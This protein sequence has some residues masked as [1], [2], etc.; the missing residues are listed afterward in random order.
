MSFKKVVLIILILF[1]SNLYSIE[2][3][4]L[5]IGNSNYA[6]APLAN[7]KND[8]L[9]VSEGF[10][11]LGYKVT[12]IIDGNKQVMEEAVAK[13][14]NNLPK[15]S[16][17]VFY[18]AGHAAQVDKVNYLIPVNE[19]INNEN[20]LKY[21]SVNVEWVIGSLKSSLSRTN[22]VIL[23]SCRD[24]PFKNSTRGSGSRGLS[25]VSSPQ[26]SG[27]EIKNSAIIY[28]TTDGN[29]A[30]D[31][32]GR[33]SPFTAAFLRNLNRRDE[34]L[35]DVMT[36]V[37]QD[38]FTSTGGKQ[39]PT[40]TNALKEK[41]YFYQPVET[42][43]QSEALGSLSVNSE[44][45]GDLYINSK[46]IAFIDIG[47]IRKIERLKPGIYEL[48]LVTDS[49]SE[50]LTV[51]VEDNRTTPISF[52]THSVNVNNEELNALLIQKQDLENSMDI[53]TNEIS[54]LEEQKKLHFSLK[55]ER[56]SRSKTAINT[57]F[58]GLIFYTIAGFSSYYTY[59][60]YQKYSNATTTDEALATRNM[61]LGFAA[62]AGASILIGVVNSI[63][64][65]NSSEK[66]KDY[67]AKERYLTSQIKSKNT[68]L[69][70]IDRE[71]KKVIQQ[72]RRIE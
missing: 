51:E 63:I 3:F 12:T 31:G 20:D 19:I 33:N 40:M 59:D 30:D 62:G 5:V 44:V 37:T 67:D 45:P 8:A 46:H 65:N 54:Q 16:M 47:E 50:F 60:S 26:T 56:D 24:N 4:A 68:D 7:T 22:I 71:Y 61:T 28:A 23:D 10:K 69:T 43:I 70:A 38:V 17:V 49:Y 13:V 32:D 14:S 2:R 18:Y 39:E 55:S 29:T 15:D 57:G 11:N 21:K 64:S 36:Y 58:T 9:D 1:C 34:T 42:T 72:I 6:T 48:E 52:I 53:L 66:V 27:T 35:L 25:V 41:V